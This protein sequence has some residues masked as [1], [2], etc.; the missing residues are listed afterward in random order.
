MTLIMTLLLLP[1][2][3]EYVNN[4]KSFGSVLIK[5]S[6]PIALKYVSAGVL[7]LDDLS[8][9]AIGEIAQN[10]AKDKINRYEKTKN[11]IVQFKDNLQKFT[12]EITKSESG[13]IKPLVFFIDELDRCRPPYALQILEKA[14]HLFNV[15]NIIFVLAL[16]KKQIGNSIRG[17]YGAD[18]DVDGYLRRFIDLN[19]FLPEPPKGA[20]VQAMFK[21]FEFDEYFNERANFS[22][23]FGYDK[24]QFISVFIELFSIFNFSLRVQEQCFTQVSIVFKT[25]SND[26]KLFPVLLATLI[27]IKNY[28]IELYR[29]YVRGEV[30]VE[31]LKEKLFSS[32]QGQAFLKGEGKYAEVVE[33]Y[34][35]YYDK[36]EEKNS[37]IKKYQDIREKNKDS[38]IY[39]KADKIIRII[40]KLE[41][42]RSTN[43]I[44]YLMKKIEL[45]DRFQS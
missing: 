45:L 13:D 38:D 36:T 27:A 15:E 34:L 7:D 3:K 40:G 14:K 25:T 21:R 11:T 43:V 5:N 32:K 8:E 37:I 2:L 16:D 31:T 19:Y 12:N 1:K 44:D 28:N 17:I 10:I 9:K 33:A 22:S 41:F 20:F 35:I 29:K 23:S 30:G 6:A 42:E 4:L 18:M 26:L 39:Y 24:E